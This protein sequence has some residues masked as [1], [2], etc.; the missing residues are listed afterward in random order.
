[1]DGQI[2]VIRVELDKAGFTNNCIMCYSIKF[3]SNLYIPFTKPQGSYLID[4]R[5]SYEIDPMNRNKAI[6]ESL[7]DEKEGADVLMIKPAGTYLD[8][9]RDIR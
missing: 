9:I 8:I 7:I 2:S 6:R 3:S 5:K 1:M 4:D